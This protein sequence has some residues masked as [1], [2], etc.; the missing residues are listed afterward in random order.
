MQ[1]W[2][3]AVPLSEHAMGVRRGRD[4]TLKDPWERLCEGS[5]GLIAMAYRF[6]STGQ[7]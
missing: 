2:I 1:R 3:G 5:R 6:M 7:A 4:A